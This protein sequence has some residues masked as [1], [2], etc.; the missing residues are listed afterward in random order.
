MS[1]KIK[2]NLSL[3]FDAFSTNYTKDMINVVPHYEK[4]MSCFSD[5][6]P[7]EFNPLHILDIGCGNGNSTAE[8]IRRFPQAEYT[9]VDASGE[10]LAICQTRFSKYNIKTIN[11]Y[12]SDFEFLN[13]QYDLIV[14]GFSLHHCKAD[15]K[16][17]LFKRI[18][19]SLKPNGYLTMSD[20]FISKTDNA[21]PALLEEWK[22]FVHENDPSGEK[23][24]WLKEHY[25][26]FDSPHNIECQ[27][28][29]M[30]K[31]GFTNVETVWNS[32]FWMHVIAG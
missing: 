12:F 31:A 7:Q 11:S 20:L 8:I 22:N 24:A 14:A 3:E 10:M 29:W 1:S 25:D 23:W 19:E 16:Q 15:E 18:K 17:V 13:N 32:G 4:L 9:L 30:N 28:E 5:C 2:E 27:K 21:H 26:A 6:L